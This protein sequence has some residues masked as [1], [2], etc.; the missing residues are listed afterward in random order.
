MSNIKSAQVRHAIRVLAEHLPY[1]IQVKDPE[2][3]GAD[4]EWQTLWDLGS[5]HGKSAAYIRLELLRET[6]PP[7]LKWRILKKNEADCYEQGIQVGRRLRRDRI[8]RPPLM[9]MP[10]HM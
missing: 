7:H 1:V 5:I 3:R 8:R 4:A 10:E 6:N 9:F 2:A